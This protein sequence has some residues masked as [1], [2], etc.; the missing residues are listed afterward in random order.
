MIYSKF[1]VESGM[2]KLY[3]HIEG[4]E[5]VECTYTDDKGSAITLTKKDTYR[6]A[7]N[8]TIKRDSDGKFVNVFAGEKCVIGNATKAPVKPPTTPTVTSVKVTA[9]TKTTYT[10]GEKLSLEGIKVE[11]EYSDGSTKDASSYTS[12]P[13]A[14]TELNEAGEVTVTITAEGKTATFTVTVNEA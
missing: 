10:K 7:P 1:D 11:L 6:C 13:E 4:Q 8:Q 14:D 9:P 5:D 12:S 3:E 2:Y